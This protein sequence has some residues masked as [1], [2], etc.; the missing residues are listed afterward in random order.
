[1]SANALFDVSVTLTGTTLGTPSN[2]VVAL[3]CQ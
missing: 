2:L 1:M 3:V